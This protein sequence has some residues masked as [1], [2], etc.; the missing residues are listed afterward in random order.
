MAR[1]RSNF[2]WLLI[3][4]AAAMGLT[5]SHRAEACP[6]RMSDSARPSCCDTMAEAP[7]AAH[8]LQL[9][10]AMLGF[11]G[12]A[13]AGHCC[14]GQPLPAVQAMARDVRLATLTPAAL[15]WPGVVMGRTLPAQ[16]PPDTGFAD[17]GGRETYLATLRLRF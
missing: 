5:A 3:L 6:L 16:G 7:A 17:P 13:G 4:V 8:S 1:N 9:C 12:C 11:R 15:A 2:V 10:A 14:C